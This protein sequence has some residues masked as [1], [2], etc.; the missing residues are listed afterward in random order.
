MVEGGVNKVAFFKWLHQYNATLTDATLEML[1]DLVCDAVQMTELHQ[2][3]LQK[4]ATL[5]GLSSVK[6]LGKVCNSNYQTCNGC[7]SRD[8]Y[9]RPC[10]RC[11]RV[12]YCSLACQAKK[13]RRHKKKCKRVVVAAASGGGDET[14]V[15]IKYAT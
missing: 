5:L 9:F 14:N 15:T 6:Q 8:R 4:R 1:H 11:Q 7:G 12:Y 3:S 2:A 10:E 13:A